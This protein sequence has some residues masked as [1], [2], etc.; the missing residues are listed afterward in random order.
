MIYTADTAAAERAKYDLVWQFPEYH[1]HSP[2]LHHV[3]YFLSVVRPDPGSSVIDI[4]AG[5]C[6][7]G[8]ELQRRGFDAW[9]LDLTDAAVPDAVDRRHFIEAPLWSHWGWRKALGWDYGYCCDVLE[10]VSPEYTMLCVDRILSYCRTTWLQVAFE[11]DKFGSMIGEDLHLTVKPFT[12][13]RDRIGG[14]G[15]LVDAR[16]LCGRGVFVVT[17]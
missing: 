4:G 11:P 3:D 7:A 2:G 6:V 1:E 8:L 13:W 5:A 10:H 16:D 12:W 17:R 15:K 9:Y 14:L